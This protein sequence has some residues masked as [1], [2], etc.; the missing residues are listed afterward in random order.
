MEK[1]GKD[2]TCF[3]LTYFFWRKT[4]GCPGHGK[5][6]QWEGR[7]RNSQNPV[8]RAGHKTSMTDVMTPSLLQNSG[9]VGVAQVQSHGTAALLAHHLSVKLHKHR[10]AQGRSQREFSA[11]SLHSLPPALS[12]QESRRASMPLSLAANISLL[13]QGDFLELPKVQGELGVMQM[14]IM[15]LS[16]RSCNQQIR[17]VRVLKKGG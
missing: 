6:E 2:R 1:A 14:L 10:S 4:T 5:K 7:P 16:S 15:L 3:S 13:R 11:V 8:Y 17:T 12:S 9:G